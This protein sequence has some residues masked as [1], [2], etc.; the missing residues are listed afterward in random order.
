MY[1]QGGSSQ[2][3]GGIY[4]FDAQSAGRRMPLD[5]KMDWPWPMQL[6]LSL[7]HPI[8]DLLPCTNASLHRPVSNW[9]QQLK[10]S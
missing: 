4:S 1:L 8:E 6:Q 5:S 3:Q 2:D 10:L 7:I 9:L